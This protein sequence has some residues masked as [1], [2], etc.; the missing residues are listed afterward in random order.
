MADDTK[1]SATFGDYSETNSDTFTN[2]RPY[3]IC[4]RSGF[5][6]D[7]RELVQEWTGLWVLPEFRDFRHPQE[8]RSAMPK[9]GPAQRQGEKP[10]IFIGASF[11]L[12]T[13]GGDRVET[14]QT[15]GYVRTEGANQ[16][17]ADDL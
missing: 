1:P 5:K 10:E 11:D 6:V 15:G 12:L 9:A 3:E 2:D 16:V 14:E 8:L 13:E 7:P 4:Q 17:S